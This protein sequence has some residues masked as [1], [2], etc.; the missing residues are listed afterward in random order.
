MSRAQN[1]PLGTEVK[2]RE[3]NF[4]LGKFKELGTSSN[5]TPENKKRLYSEDKN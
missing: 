5:T 2:L 3:G 4:W 1:W